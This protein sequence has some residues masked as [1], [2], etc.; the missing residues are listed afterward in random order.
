[1]KILVL[2]GAGF[3]GP[4][5]MRRILE[6][7]HDVVCVDVNTN[8]PTIAPLRDRIQVLRGDITAET[9]AAYAQLTGDFNPLHFDP[10]FVSRT[11]FGR[12][13]AQGGIA[14]GLLHIA[15]IAF[16]LR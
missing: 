9:V 6:R 16:G 4:R 10:D 1:M 15:G 3:I 7:G 8:S 12:L 5:V 11:R 2:G 14:T 13:M